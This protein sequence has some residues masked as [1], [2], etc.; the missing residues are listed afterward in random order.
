VII[1]SFIVQ[2][3]PE[4]LLCQTLSQLSKD[5]SELLDWAPPFHSQRGS[6]VSLSTTVV[7][8]APGIKDKG[9]KNQPTYLEAEFLS[10][11]LPF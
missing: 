9:V 11:D 2:I 3:F 10:L 6:T 5:S 1:F 8:K 7:S 4:H